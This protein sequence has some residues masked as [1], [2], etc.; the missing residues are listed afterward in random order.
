MPRCRTCVQLLSLPFC[1]FKNVGDPFRPFPRHQSPACRGVFTPSPLSVVR[2]G[3]GRAPMASWLARGSVAPGSAR[4][5][6]LVRAGGRELNP[7][8]AS[9]TRSSG[10]IHTLTKQPSQEGWRLYAKS[11]ASA[12]SVTSSNSS[13]SAGR[14]ALNAS[15]SRRNCTPRSVV[16]MRWPNLLSC[17][18]IS[19]EAF[20]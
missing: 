3:K 10:D 20:T 15:P 6:C 8:R 13:A 9:L 7:L 2:A 18:Q 4:S 12:P 17:A 1:A 19:T 5:C 11:P 14:P 16:L